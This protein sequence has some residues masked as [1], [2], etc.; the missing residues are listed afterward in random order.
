MSHGSKSK[1]ATAV[2][3]NLKLVLPFPAM[4]KVSRVMRPTMGGPQNV[5]IT[6]I[7]VTT[8]KNSQGPV[9]I[10]SPFRR[11]IKWKIK[12][13]AA[14]TKSGIAIAA[15]DHIVPPGYDGENIRLRQNSFM[16]TAQRTS[17]TPKKN[18]DRVQKTR[19]CET[20]ATAGIQLRDVAKSGPVSVPSWQVHGFGAIAL[21]SGMQAAN[22]PQPLME[23]S[24]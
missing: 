6:T 12:Y 1:P 18:M 13:I 19:C 5:A 8:A 22:F 10:S 14:R 17:P 16:T 9:A 15:K 11:L 24:T 2:F 7:V 20:D 21:R 3:G 23:Q 4:M